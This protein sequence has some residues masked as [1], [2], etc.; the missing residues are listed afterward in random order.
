MKI[1][2]RLYIT[3]HQFILHCDDLLQLACIREHSSTC[4]IYITMSVPFANSW[5]Y[6]V[7][8]LCGCKKTILL[9]IIIVA[10]LKVQ[11]EDKMTS[12]THDEAYSVFPD[13]TDFFSIPY[14]SR[15]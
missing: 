5:Y 15:T 6:Q 14:P 13:P 12:V 7:R 2:Y 3:V 4:Y 8:S 10:D 11:A 9:C 1:L